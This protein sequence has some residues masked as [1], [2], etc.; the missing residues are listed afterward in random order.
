MRHR[1]SP[2]R[3]Q[4]DAL[5]RAHQG[6]HRRGELSVLHHRAERGRGRGPG[7]APEETRRHRQ[8]AQGHPGHRGVRRHRGPGRRRLEG[9][10]PG[11]PIP[12]QHPRDPGDR[13]RGSLLRGR[14]R[15]PREQQGGPDFRHRGD[16]HGAGTRRHAIDREGQAPLRQDAPRGR[17]GSHED[18]AAP[19]ARRKGAR[20]LSSGP[21]DGPHGRRD[22][23]AAA[24]A[25]LRSAPSSKAR[26]RASTTKRRGCSSRTWA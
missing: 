5:Q 26:S 14:Q 23:A 24:A 3:R 18:G 10:R 11:Q 16:P 21:G 1:R 13:E 17:Q 4:V 19:R 9:R 20:R 7:S 8:A 15:D 12:R 22:G 2:Q 25:G 6:G